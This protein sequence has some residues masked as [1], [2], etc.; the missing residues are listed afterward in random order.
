MVTEAEVREGHLKMLLAL[1]MEEGATSQGLL[2]NSRKM[3]GNGLSQRLQK[4]LSPLTPWLQD[5][6]TQE[7]KRIKLCCFKPLSSCSFVMATIGN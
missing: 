3:Q 5:F 7:L 4:G 1:R 2:A 6:R